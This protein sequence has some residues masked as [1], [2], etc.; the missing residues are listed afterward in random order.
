M[1][2]LLMAK[3]VIFYGKSLFWC[4]LS[5]FWDFMKTDADPHPLHCVVMTIHQGGI[6]PN[7][8]LYVKFCHCVN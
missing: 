1:M 3:C 2:L 6:N 7:I 4:K 5:D 8:T